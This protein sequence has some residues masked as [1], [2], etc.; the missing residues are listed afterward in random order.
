MASGETSEAFLSSLVGRKLASIGRHEF[1]W[2]FSFD[3]TT[4][5]GTDGSW[6][7][8]AEGRVAVSNLDDG[9]KYGLCDAVDA[10]ARALHLIL[11]KIV[12]DASVR[13]DTG[14]LT[15]SFGDDSALEV[16]TISSGYE[17]WQLNKPQ[18]GTLV[19]TGGG[20]LVFA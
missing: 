17:A 18:A 16:L 4:V 14:D 7:V 9:Q 8:L 6:R 3:D 5:L 20:K 1:S 11:G 19:C 10:R 2:S 13:E 15:I 12:R